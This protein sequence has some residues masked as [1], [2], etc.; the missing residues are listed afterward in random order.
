MTETHH[1][2]RLATAG[3][4][5]SELAASQLKWGEVGTAGFDPQNPD[6]D[7]LAVETA[8]GTRDFLA[9]RALSREPAAAARVA[10]EAAR[11]FARAARARPDLLAQED[12]SGRSPLRILVETGGGAAAVEAALAAHPGGR[13]AAAQLRIKGDAQRTQ[14][15]AAVEASAGAD[16]EV[17]RLLAEAWPEAAAKAD[18]EGFLPLHRALRALRSKPACAGAVRALLAAN[19][20]AAAQ[21][22]PRGPLPLHAAV[23][24]GDAGVVAA[25]LAAAGPGGAA[26]VAGSKLRETAL[27][28]A[29]RSGRSPEIVRALLL[30]EAAAGGPSAAAA[31]ADRGGRTPL[32]VLLSAAVRTAAPVL[33]ETLCAAAAKQ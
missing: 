14:L 30:A 10:E 1:D 28:L 26:A 15:H 2:P 7:V 6:P 3:I 20:A 11:V 21:R 8:A 33:G 23:R 27:H 12:E 32:H 29:V 31:A 24:T 4:P 9:P 16:A 13:A 5:A 19:P 22:A 17:I 25:V 18:S